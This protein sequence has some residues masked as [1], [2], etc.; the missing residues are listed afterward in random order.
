MN[1]TLGFGVAISYINPG[2]DGKFSVNW[3]SSDLYW[4][5]LEAEPLVWNGVGS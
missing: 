1:L 3:I 5:W 2:S 4:W